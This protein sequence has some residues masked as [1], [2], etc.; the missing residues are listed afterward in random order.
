MCHRWTERELLTHWS[1]IMKYAIKSITTEKSIHRPLVFNPWAVCTHWW[2]SSN[3]SLS[4]SHSFTLPFPVW[5]PP[6]PL[7]SSE[8]TISRH[9]CLTQFPTIQFKKIEDDHRDVEWTLS[10]SLISRLSNNTDDDAHQDEVQKKNDSVRWEE[11]R[12]AHEVMRI[13]RVRR[14]LKRL[15]DSNR[16]RSTDSDKVTVKRS[17]KSTGVSFENKGWEEEDETDAPLE[18]TLSSSSD[19]FVSLAFPESH[20]LNL[21]WV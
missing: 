1:I 20:H 18:I 9:F 21:P 5:L 3:V 6:P 11:G 7:S 17:Q 8:F 19:D 15:S 12:Q 10:A 16:R 14:G 2:S 4:D 13:Q